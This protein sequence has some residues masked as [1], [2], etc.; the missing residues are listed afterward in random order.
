MN[1]KKLCL[2]TALTLAMTT[3]QVVAQEEAMMEP[4]SFVYAT[5]H[6][7]K[8]DKQSKADEIVKEHDAPVYN[9]M[10]EE[11]L[12][13]GWGWLA[14]HTGGHWRRVSF[15]SA[16]SLNALLDAQDAFGERMD[17][18]APKAG[19]EMAKI[20]TSHDDYIWR[21]EA[22]GGTNA[23]GRSI[24]STYFICDEAREERAD[25]IMK[26]NFAPIYNRYVSEGK[27]GGWGWLSHWVGGQYR[28]LLTISGADMKTVLANRDALIGELYAEGNEAGTEF[29]DICSSHVDYMWMAVDGG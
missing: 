9:Q 26:E 5:Y 27:L 19:E 22:G 29:N 20:C 15:Y 7:C 3:P 21:A 10:K 28:R 1:F 25:E 12:V 11:G 18:K 24:F 16:P 4:E 23:A 8:L 6:H 14:H 13:T 17:E 2:G